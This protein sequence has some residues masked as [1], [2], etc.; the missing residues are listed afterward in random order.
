MLIPF[1][2][3]GYL[4]FSNK[5]SDSLHKILNGFKDQLWPVILEKKEIYCANSYIT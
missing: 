3:L 4:A 1:V 5:E 2:G